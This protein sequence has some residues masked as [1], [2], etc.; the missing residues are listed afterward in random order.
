VRRDSSHDV[1]SRPRH[2]GHDP[3]YELGLAHRAL[4]SE[5]R[6]HLTEDLVRLGILGRETHERARV[7]KPDPVNLNIGVTAYMLTLAV[8]IPISGWMADRFGAR[9]VFAAAIAIFTGASVLCGLSQGQW[10][11]IA[12]RLLQGAGGAVMMA[13]G[14]PVM[15]RATEKRDLLRLISYITLAGLVAPVLGPPVGVAIA[16]Y[17]AGVGSSS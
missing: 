8:F 12:C 7:S 16:T 10:S 9:Q 15:L 1:G 2:H 17:S 3:A 4:R 11:F 5:Q 6:P 13:V 14:R